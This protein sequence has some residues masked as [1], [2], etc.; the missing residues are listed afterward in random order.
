MRRRRFSWHSGFD[1]CFTGSL[2]WFRL[3]IAVGLVFCYLR[4]IID[5]RISR[6]SGLLRIWWMEFIWVKSF[7]CRKWDGS[8]NWPASLWALDPSPFL[9]FTKWYRITYISKYA[10]KKWSASFKPMMFMIFGH[11]KPPFTE[12][13]CFWHSKRLGLHLWDDFWWPKRPAGWPD[14]MATCLRSLRKEK[15]S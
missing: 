10:S 14:A 3:T 4:K 7:S 2:D 9:C 1:E 8:Q 5:G 15:I 11:Q 13:S 6:L 12:P